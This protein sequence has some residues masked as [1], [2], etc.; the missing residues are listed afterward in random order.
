MSKKIN[1]SLPINERLG[2]RSNVSKTTRIKLNDNVLTFIQEHKEIVEQNKE[3][4]YI[5]SFRK[6]KKTFIKIKHLYCNKI[7]DTRLDGWKDGYRPK[8]CCL[9]LILLHTKHLK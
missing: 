1:E 9:L 5:G 2:Q 4:E 8:C 6:S 3:Y 7:T